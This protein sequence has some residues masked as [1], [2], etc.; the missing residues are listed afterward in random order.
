MGVKSVFSPRQAL[1]KV[2]FM[3][4][5]KIKKVKGEVRK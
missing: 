4:V 2:S 1:R 3:I 5:L